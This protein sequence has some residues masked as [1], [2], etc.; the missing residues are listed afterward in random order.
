MGLL[1]PRGPQPLVV[2]QPLRNSK[3]MATTTPWE[4]AKPWLTATM[5]AKYKT[6]QVVQAFPPTSLQTTRRFQGDKLVVG[7]HVAH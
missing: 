1:L 7:R 4:V 2:S 6:P 5:V 3:A